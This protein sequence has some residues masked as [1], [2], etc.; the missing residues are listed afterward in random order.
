MVGSFLLHNLGAW[1][2]CVCV[3]FRYVGWLVGLY[4]TLISWLVGC[5]F[6]QYADWF[7]WLFLGVRVSCLVGCYL[8]QY[9]D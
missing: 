3:C 5:I 9:A 7:V 8:A 6:I 1:S 2:V 4:I